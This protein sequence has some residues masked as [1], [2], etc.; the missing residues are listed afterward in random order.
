MA[1][2]FIPLAHFPTK[3]SWP[4]IRATSYSDLWRLSQAQWAKTSSETQNQKTTSVPWRVKVWHARGSFR[5]RLILF[6]VLSAQN[7]SE[8]LLFNFNSVS[9]WITLLAMPLVSI[10]SKN[11]THSIEWLYLVY[12]LTVL[13]LFHQSNFPPSGVSSLLHSSLVIRSIQ[14]GLGFV[15]SKSTSIIWFECHTPILH[16]LA[17]Y[18]SNIHYMTT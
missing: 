6:D 10:C 11:F 16:G 3:L 18:S 9:L 12:A 2:L 5:H 17:V 1:I 4:Q 8:K 15:Q 14:T 13:P 7:S